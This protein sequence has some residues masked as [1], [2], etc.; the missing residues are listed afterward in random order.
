M[1]PAFLDTPIDRALRLGLDIAAL[2]QRLV[3]DNIA[4]VDTPGY[5]GLRLNFDA[6]YKEAKRVLDAQPKAPHLQP[7]QFIV[8]DETTTMRLDGNNIDP[9]KEMVELTQNALY[10]VALTELINRRHAY[11]LAAITEGRG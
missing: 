5:K 9:E 1:R 11:L 8:R 3:A 10:Y 4:N 7:D 6:Y 2:N